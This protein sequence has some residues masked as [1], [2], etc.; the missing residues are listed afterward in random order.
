MVTDPGYMGMV[1]HI[2]VHGEQHIL[3]RSG[4]LRSGVVIQ[5]G[6]VPHKHAGM[7]SFDG[8]TKVSTISLCVDGD[9]RVLE[10]QHQWSCL[11]RF[12]S[13]NTTI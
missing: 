4:H 11:Y 1:H 3:N 5:H 6:N 2:P 8:S 13:W 12:C 9:G 10:C 7:L